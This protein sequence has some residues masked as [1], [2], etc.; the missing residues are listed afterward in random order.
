MHRGDPVQETEKS[1]R[2]ILQLG[3]M[4][5]NTQKLDSSTWRHEK[6]TSKMSTPIDKKPEN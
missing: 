5:N 2:W 6:T 4:K 1:S 3:G